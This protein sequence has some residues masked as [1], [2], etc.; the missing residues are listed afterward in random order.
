[1][2][3][4]HEAIASNGTNGRVSTVETHASS[5]SIQSA[6]LEIGNVFWRRKW[7]IILVIMLGLAGAAFF[8]S[9]TGR[10]YDSTAQLLVLKKRLDTTP[11]TGPDQVRAPDDF[12][13]TH[14]LL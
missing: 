4:S 2:N 10:R 11:I 7:R 14:M 6:W 5:E 3:V 9:V 8:C 13:S 12:L 1:M